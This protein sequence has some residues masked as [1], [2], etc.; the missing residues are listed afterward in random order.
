MKPI[1]LTA[2]L[3][4]A[5]PGMSVA[6]APEGLPLDAQAGECF[7][8][9]LSPDSVELVTERVIDTKASVEVRTVPAQFETVQ[10]QVL[11][12][13][14]TTVYK[15]VPA[16]FKTVA[17][18]VEIEPGITKTV[19]KQVLVEPAR[20]IEDRIEPRYETVEVQKLVAPQRQ[21]RIEIPATYKLV[22]RYVAEGGT[23]QW[24]P[25]LCET[26]A[27]PQKIAEIQSALS[28][29]GHPIVI[30]GKFG[31]QTFAAMKA[32]QA[33]QGL[34]V[35]VLTVSTVKRLGVSPS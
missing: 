4:W 20:I 29:A 31:P 8:E 16:V 19:M 10:E 14:G 26:N 23:A 7:A 22:D 24:V 3:A 17:E 2:A 32:Y 28:D 11:V 6:Q 34:P 35:G 21:E 27:S 12:R 15:S 1:I 9:I 5:M 25:I 30:D 18:A 13:E 33:E